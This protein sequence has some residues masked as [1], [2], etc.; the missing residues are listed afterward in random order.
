LQVFLYDRI[1]ALFAS[2][3]YFPPEATSS[4]QRDLT[5]H[6]T[7]TSLQMHRGEEGVRLLDELRG[8]QKLSIPSEFTTNEI[9]DIKNKMV[10][11][12][13]ETFNAALDNPVHFQVCGF[14]SPH[15]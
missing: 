5:P 10:A 1:L 14:L 8:C 9:Q 11:I 6:L 2:V 4:G 7:N 15:F 13:G 12:I 3:P